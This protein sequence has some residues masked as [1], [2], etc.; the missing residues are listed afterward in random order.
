M[1]IILVAC[2]VAILHTLLQLQGQYFPNYLLFD[3]IYLL[4]SRQHHRLFA[5]PD[6]LRTGYKCKILIGKLFSHRK[7]KREEERKCAIKVEKTTFYVKYIT[8]TW[9][10]CL[11][12]GL[13]CFLT[14]MHH[15]ARWFVVKSMAFY[16]LDVD[17]LSHLRES[18]KPT[19]NYDSQ[20][21]TQI[22]HQNG[23]R[24]KKRGDISKFS[25]IST[26]KLPH[27]IS[28]A[29]WNLIHTYGQQLQQIIEATENSENIE[30]MKK[31]NAPRTKASHTQ[32]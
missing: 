22:Y 28:L 15:F 23:L 6:P 14:W 8:F 12:F 5:A 13:K 21:I 29:F 24:Q 4:L 1:A 11:I 18:H 30:R 16:E 31:T 7:W 9:I 19:Q 26:T 17:I 32:R 20:R 10:M 27:L 2:L 3:S 25:W